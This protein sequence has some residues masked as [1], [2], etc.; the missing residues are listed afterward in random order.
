MTRSNNSMPLVSIII[1]TYRSTYTLKRAIDS[2]LIQTYKNIEVIV[3][4]DNSPDSRYR[5]STEKI[6][7]KYIGDERVVYIKHKRNMNGSAAR[8]TGFYHSTGDFICLLDDDDY[9]Y[10]NKIEKQI[11]LLLRVNSYDA[12]GC[13]WD[14]RGKTIQLANK[15]DFTK[16]ILTGKNT[17]NT[18]TL[19]IRRV[20]FKALNGF[21]AS[22]TR[23]QDY[24]FL[25][26]FFMLY[27]IG[28]VPLP[29][30]ALGT[31]G[32]D[33]RPNASDLEKVKELFLVD[34]KSIYSKDK[35]FKKKVIASNYV[36]VMLGY[37]KTADMRNTLRVLALL[38][39]NS[40]I[41]F[42][43]YLSISLYEYVKAHRHINFK[44][45]SSNNE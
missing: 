31:N 29:L 26:R 34:F 24:E 30:L 20:A 14:R 11:S 17:P 18:C 38:L 10:P 15:N 43:K 44:M 13:Y 40:P 28:I 3:V 27:K 12:V 39:C 37:I 8:N 19:M 21:D 7:S 36:E 16:E 41:N 6:M 42:C 35:K 5:L 32:I 23:H 4:D 33:N 9:F 25:L 2:C 22:Y 45:V 1:P